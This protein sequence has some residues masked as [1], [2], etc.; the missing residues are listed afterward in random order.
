MI[1]WLISSIKKLSQ[2]RGQFSNKT[3]GNIMAKNQS[4]SPE[5]S[6]FATDI[7]I[8][9]PQVIRDRKKSSFLQT[10]T[11]NFSYYI[12]FSRKGVINGKKNERKF[13]TSHQMIRHH[14][15][16]TLVY[17]FLQKPNGRWGKLYH[18][19]ISALILV[20]II[21]TILSTIQG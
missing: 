5:Y 21:M 2:R 20:C 18:I 6:H 8:P 7:E 17:G 14:N 12:H 1:Y 15:Q 4:H 13:S 11:D 10:F 3:N 19:C 9:E 16:K